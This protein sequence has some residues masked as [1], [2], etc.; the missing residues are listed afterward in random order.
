MKLSNL[1]VG[2]QLGLGLGAILI[3]VALLGVMAWVQADRLWRETQGL[4]EHPLMVSRAVGEI[5]ADILAM[6]RGMNDL[7]LATDDQAIASALRAIATYEADAYR[8]FAVV[9]ER[10]LGSR[11]DIDAAYDAFAA[12]K[13]IRDETVRL[14][15]AG[16]TPEAIQQFSASGE[17]GLHVDKLLSLVQKINDFAGV[18][19]DVFYQEAQQERNT[20]RRLLAVVFGVILLLSAGISYF[21]LRGI[22]G[23]LRELTVVTEQYRQ[24]QLSA[25][26]RYANSSANEF[27]TLAAAFNALVDT[28]QDDM[29]HREQVAQIADVMLRE[30]ELCA[31]CRALLT[32][33]LQHTGSQVGAVYLL[34]AS[35]TAFEHYESIGLS[36]SSR[37]SFSAAER[38]GEFGAVLATQQVQ[39]LKE[40]P[41]DTRFAFAAVSG[42]FMPR[43][44]ITLPILSGVDVVAVISLASI[45]GY[46]TPA[47]RL[48][49]DVLSVLTARLNGVL[50]M[51]QVRAFSEKLELQN[52]ELAQQAQELAVQADELHQQNIELQLQKQQLDEAVR[53]K[54]RFLSN[55]SHELR[56]PLNS[57]IA[58]AGVLSRRLRNAIPAEELGY[59]DVI[60]RNGQNLL[61]LINEILDLS[62]IE[63][64]RDEVKL[65]AFTLRDLTDEV[66][67]MIAPQ[68]QE[69]GLA[70]LN[71]VADD[72]PA[73]TSDFDKCRHILQN[74]LGNA[75]KFTEAGRV[76]VASALAGDEIHVIVSDTGIGIA[77]E[78]LPYIF[79][80]FR[81]GDESS[82]RKY[83]GTGLGLAIARRYATLLGGRITVNSNPGAGSVFTLVLPRAPAEPSA[84]QSVLPHTRAWPGESRA[85][86]VPH[87]KCILLVEDSEPAV[88]QMTDILTEHGYQVQVA[89]NGREALVAVAG[90]P[91]DAMIL[92]LMMPEVDGFVVLQAIRGAE[93]T[94]CLPVLILTAK[95][96]TAEELSFLKGNRIHQ[97]IQKGDISKAELLAAVEKLV[98]N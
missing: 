46:P 14:V 66:V 36:A 23:P 87:G 20:L 68:A 84:A 13:T 45:Q 32:V 16:R 9:H 60:E 90:T 79:D 91:P 38:E 59:L 47:I 73:I 2:A 10:F 55:M 26:S 24:G 37:T 69:R 34:N 8:Q 43:E 15:R 11:A 27:G 4:Y 40:I 65:S 78:Q 30:E 17:D 88:V 6:H 64:G 93:Q 5:K 95:H 63:A 28:V 57:V 18:R 33:L 92:D 56:T 72:L 7:I 48:I 35:H 77:A 94:A 83:G 44:I 58:L 96:V 21:L 19:G 70:L 89:R 74:L 97:L 39:R 54:S 75:V 42:D 52:R 49:D 61:T 71:R 1:P 31:F 25:R 51:R 98:A 86:P 67:A 62:R 3:F 12:W 80:E 22:R 50:A 76:E 53:Q 81:Q 82:S 85:R 41:P 29:Q